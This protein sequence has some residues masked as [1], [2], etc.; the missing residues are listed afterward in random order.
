MDSARRKTAIAAE[1]ARREKA[2]GVPPEWWVYELHR[3]YGERGGPRTFFPARFQDFDE[4]TKASGGW[5]RDLMLAAIERGEP[6]QFLPEP[7]N[8]LPD[9]AFAD[10]CT[11]G[12]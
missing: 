1:L 12:F 6:I 5:W 4:E 3:H 9:A 8:D 11:W 7:S 10:Y 2:S